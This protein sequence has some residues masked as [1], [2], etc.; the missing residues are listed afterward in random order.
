MLELKGITFEIFESIPRLLEPKPTAGAFAILLLKLWRRDIS[1]SGIN[2]GECER[3]CRLLVTGDSCV[4]GE[5]G[6]GDLL[7][8][9]FGMTD[10]KDV[11]G[12]GG[13]KSCA[14]PTRDILT[15]GLMPIAT[16]SSGEVADEVMFS[17][18]PSCFEHSVFLVSIPCHQERSQH[19]LLLRMK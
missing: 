9:L 1:G 7:S 2:D 15:D 16:S 19:R 11:D 18:S 4:I 8:D 14:M 12:D 5:I 10:L 3:D 6:L 17:R 13:R